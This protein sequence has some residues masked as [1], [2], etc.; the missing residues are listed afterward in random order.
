M[1]DDRTR[2]TIRLPTHTVEE[3]QDQLSH[4]NTDAAR[5]QFLAQFY[6]DYKELRGT[7]QP[8]LRPVYGSRPTPP[9]HSAESASGDSGSG[10][11]SSPTDAHRHS[12]EA[13]PGDEGEN[14]TEADERNENQYSQ[15]PDQ[16]D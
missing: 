12:D 3:L 6:L 4:F 5:F 10:N 16:D 7:P 8:I 1:A 13:E 11:D 14:R 15:G 9:A 2:L